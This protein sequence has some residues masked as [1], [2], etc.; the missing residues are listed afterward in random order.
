MTEHRGA[1]T[2]ARTFWSRVEQ[3]ADRPASLRSDPF[4]SRAL[5]HGGSG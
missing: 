3:S 4:I 1:A 2:L 5:V